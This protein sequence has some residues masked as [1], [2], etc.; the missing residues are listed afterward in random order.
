MNWTEE[1]KKEIESIIIE[2][3]RFHKIDSLDE[4]RLDRLAYILATVQHETAGTFQP[5]EEYGK[6]KGRNYGEEINGH[7]Y[8]GRGYVQLTWLNNYKVL[9]EK[10]GLDLVNNPELALNKEI[11]LKI[12]FIGMEEGLFT[13]RKLSQYFN[14]VCEDPISARKIINGKDKAK[15]IAELYRNFKKYIAGYVGTIS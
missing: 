7:R 1:Q 6:G 11:A 13:G 14:D 2:Y 8:Y 10:L 15:Q 12:M 3:C 9:G 5:I 4:V